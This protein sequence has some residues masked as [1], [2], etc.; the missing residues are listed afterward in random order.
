[1][2]VEE[3]KADLEM[4]ELQVLRGAQARE[5]FIGS[6]ADYVCRKNSHQFVEYSSESTCLAVGARHESEPRMREEQG[7]HTLFAK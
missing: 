5:D 7:K 4:R 6:Q 2:M 1:M 3:K